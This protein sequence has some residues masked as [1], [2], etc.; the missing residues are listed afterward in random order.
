MI[1]LSDLLSERVK[2]VAENL[3]KSLITLNG[4]DL[5]KANI[6]LKELREHV[7]ESIQETL[8]EQAKRIIELLRKDQPML[9]SDMQMI[10]KWLIGDAEYYT[11]IENNFND[12]IEECKR[13]RKTM[14]MYATDRLE[15]DES[16]LLKLGALLTDLKF[17]LNDVIRYVEAR[18]R[19][20]MFRES[21]GHGALDKE[22][23]KRLADLIERQLYSYEF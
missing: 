18:D 13:L 22:G 20:Q 17:T 19:K 6:P 5:E 7:R 15:T 1:R 21:L 12:W 23:K 3:E 2:M 4:D 9:S 8:A 14:Q 10:E 16:S 11:Q